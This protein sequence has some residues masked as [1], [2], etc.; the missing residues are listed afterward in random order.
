[1]KNFLLFIS[2]MLLGLFYACD[3]EVSQSSTNEVLEWPSSSN[4]AKPWTRW[5][6]HGS[7]VTKAGIT[8]ELEAYKKAGLGGLELTPIYGVKG[9]EENFLTYLSPEWTSMLEFTLQEA[10]RL[11]LGIDMATGTG[12]P[13]GGPW[14]DQETACKY[15]AHKT[16][17]LQQG[18][19]LA[20]KI[21]FIQKPLLRTVNTPG[22][23]ITD[24]SLPVSGNENL[25]KLALDQVR[26]EQALP[27]LSL[28]AYSE[29]K[30][31]IHLTDRVKDGML[32]W[33]A[34]QGSR[35]VYAVF[36]GGHGKMV[37]VLY[38]LLRLPTL[39]GV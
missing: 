29:N 1:M 32:D 19:K 38:T 18:E 3:T 8:A 13:F 34:P 12:W 33:T 4:T 22:L 17:T 16:Y 28:V 27:L 39:L 23:K 11:G 36:A 25:Q 2:V 9:D 20:E 15:V 14:V 30:E 37:A 5:W 10:D 21:E 35:T 7:S 26:F 31:A 6:W 24:L